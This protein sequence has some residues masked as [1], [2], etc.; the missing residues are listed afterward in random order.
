MKR[1]S[2]KDLAL[3]E[4]KRALLEQL[5]REEGLDSPDEARIPRSENA[6]RARLSFA[7]QRLWFINELEPG[8]PVYTNHFAARLTGT[9]N[10]T[11]L[12]QSVNELVQHHDALRTTF[13]V[14]D[15]RPVQL[16]GPTLSVAMPVV[17]LRSISTAARGPEVRRLAVAEARQPFDL[18]RGPLLR[19][20][21]VRLGSAES[22]L[23]FTVHHIISDGW[24][25][26]VFVTQLGAV[27]EAFCAGKG[28]PLPPL[29]IQYGD[30]AQWQQESLDVI[31]PHLPYWREKLADAQPS[32]D[33]PADHQRPI[34]Q[35]LNGASYHF[36]LPAA[37]N[38]ALKSL[39]RQQSVTLF[40]VL[41]AAFKALLYRYTGQQD[42]SVGSPIAS[43]NRAELKD[44]F[45]C[46]AN[47]LVLRTDVDADLTFQDLLDRVKTTCV[48]AYEHQDMPFEKLVE[49]LQP[50]RDLSRSPL[51]Q[52][53]FVL[54]SFP[55]PNA[56]ADLKLDLIEVDSGTAKFDLT[57]EVLE[58]AE[59]LKATFEY[60]TV[61]FDSET[62]MRMAEHLRILLNGVA[63]DP[64][65][66]VWELPL[67]SEDEKRQLIW[68]FGEDQGEYD[69][70][71]CLHDLFERQARLTP[72]R[73]ALV[74]GDL[75]LSYRELDRRA[76]RLARL[77]T[78]C[79]ARPESLVAVCLPRTAE[80]VTSLLAVLKSGAAYVPLDPAYP[81]ARLELMME[82]SNSLALITD[83]EL[84]GAVPAGRAKVICVEDID[85]ACERLDHSG[86]E[87]GTNADHA[88]RVVSGNLAYLIY[89]SGSTGRPKGVAIEHRSAV[90]MVSWSLG[91][92]TSEELEG[93]LAST[94]ICFDLS[95][96]ELMVP[97]SAGGAVLLVDNAL[98][99]LDEDVRGQVSLINTVP[100]A[101]GEVIRRAA[102]PESV[103]TVNLAGE[104]LSAKL[105][106]EIY[107]GSRAR[108]VVNLY[109]PSEDTTYSTIEEV[110]RGS[111]QVLIGRPISW[112]RAYVADGRGE[113][114]ARGVMGELLI[115]GE[116]LAR[117]YYG[118]AE[119]T[120]ERFIADVAGM[121]AGARVYR[122][123]DVCRVREEKKL[124]YL[125]RGDGQVKVRGYRIELGEVEEALRKV[126]GVKEAA[127]VVEE[128]GGVKRLI[129]Y[130]VMEEEESGGGGRR[131]REEVKEGVPGYMV[132]SQMVEIEAM[133]LTPNRKIDRRAL[134]RIGATPDTRDHVGPRNPMEEIVCEIWAGV[135]GVEKVGVDDNLF[136]IGGH[137]LL[138][139]QIVSRV[140]SLLG[141]EVSLRRLFTA[142]TVAAMAA[143][144]EES[145][146][147]G[148]F[149]SAPPIARADRTR[150]LLLSFAQQRLWLIDRMHP[151]SPVYNIACAVRMLGQLDAAALVK[152]LNEIV[153]RHESLRT[154]FVSIDGEPTQ[155]V[156]DFAGFD[157]E[158]IDLT[159]EGERERERR[160]CELEREEAERGFD[161]ERGSLIRARLLQLGDEEHVLLLTMHHI[162]SDA[163]SI[164][165][166]AR[167]LTQLYEAYREGMP[168]P[169][170][171]LA[172]QYA[173]YAAWQRQWLQ[174]EALDE[175]L[176]YW[177]RQ[178]SGVS[179]LELPTDR[180]RPP[181]ISHRGA[182]ESFSLPA[183]LTQKLNEMSR[184]EGVTLFMSL[185]AGFQLLLARYSGQ[186]DIAVGTSL[187]GRNRVETEALIGF[188]VNTL[189]MRTDLS[190]SPTVKGLL[191]RVRDTALGAYAHQDLPFERL[192]EELQP[193]RNLS[194][195]PLC[196]VMLTFL[197]MP[198]ENLALP[199]LSVVE[200]P[201]RAETAKFD[202]T[203]SFAQQGGEIRGHLQYSTDLFDRARVVRMLTHLHRVFEGMVADADRAVSLIPLLSEEEWR[204]SVVEWNRT[205]AP[206]PSNL[207]VHEKFA[208][209]AKQSPDR[210]AAV[211]E[212]QQISYAEL[213][214]RA[215]QLARHLREVGVG[216]ESRV[217]L[218]IGRGLEMVIG[219]LGVLKAG[220]A[221]VP[222]DPSYPTARLE[223]MLE[224]SSATAVVTLG[225]LV[226]LLPQH[227][228]R[229]VAMDAEWPS[230]SAH[231][232]E[233]L[234]TNVS[235]DNLAYVIYTSG[236]TGKPKGV[237]VRHGAVLNLVEALKASVYANRTPALRVG[238][239]AS[240]CFDASVKQ[241]FQL[242]EGHTLSIVPEAVRFDAGE[243]ASYLA[244][245][246]VD[247]L[248]CTP[249]QLRFLI[250]GLGPTAAPAMMLVGGEAIDESLWGALARSTL[251]DYFN[252]YGP[253]E[254]TVD[255]TA[256]K[257]DQTRV[258]GTIGRPI[259]NAQVYLLDKRMNPV[260]VGV[261]GEMYIAG[262]GLARGYID[263]PD[264]SA[265]RFIPN[266]FAQ[267][268]GARLYRTGDLAQYRASGEIEFLGR[269]DQQV[270][271]R[272]F[273]IELGEIEAILSHHSAI[274]QVV[275][276]VREDIP[277]ERRLAAYL[278]SNERLDAADLQE[279]LRGKL[280]DYMVPTAF[281]Q[282]E[283]I[284][285]TPNGKVDRIALSG[286]EYRPHKQAEEVQGARTATEE[287]I[288]AIWAE[289]LS[290]EQVSIHDNFFDLGGHSLLASRMI[291]RINETFKIELPLRRLFETPTI[292]ALTEA[293]ET[294]MRSDR[295]Q[296]MLPL[297]RFTAGDKLPLS[298]AQQRVWFLDQLEPNTSTYNMPAALRMEGSV[299]IAALEQSIG[300][301]A[302]R[303]EVL[304]ARFDSRQGRPVQMIEPAQPFRIPV[305]DLS[306]LDYQE[307]DAWATRLATQE[308]ARPFDLAR[309]KLLRARLIRLDRQ[310]HLLLINM[311]H[312]VSDGWSVGVFLSE[313]ASLYQS[314]SAGLTS[315][316]DELPIQYS[317]Y[318]RWQKEG[319]Q[320]EL[321]ERQLD[322][323]KQRLA[324]RLPVLDLPTDRPRPTM[325][326][327]CGARHFIVLPHGLTESLKSLGRQE[328]STPYVTLLAAF[329]TLLYRYTSQKDI[330]VGSP[331]AGRGRTEV[332]GLIGFF[333]NTLALRTDLSGD[334]S[335]RDLI[336]TETEIFLEAYAN[337]DVPFEKLVEELQPERS[338]S[339]MPVF[340]VMFVMGEPSRL[341]EMD[342]LKLSQIDVDSGAA[343]F[344]LTVWAKE[345][346][347]GLEMRWEYSA[348]LFD[349]STIG[350]MSHNFQTLLEAIVNDPSQRITLLSLLT[351]EERRELLLGCEKAVGADEGEA[352]LHELFEQ[353]VRRTPDR[354]ALVVG[355]L[356][357]S[358][359]ELDD[360]ASRIARLLRAWGA[361]PESLVGV[362]L[363][364]TAELVIALLG[365]LK[366]GSAYVPLDPTYP[367]AR[368]G[369][370]MEDSNS[371]MLITQRE[372]AELVP[373]GRAKVIC[374]E[375]IEEAVAAVGESRQEARRAIW[376]NL[377]Y[378][379]YTSG[380]TGRP[381][382]VA[383]THRSAV[384]LVRWALG[385]FAEEE[386]AGVLASTSICFD[387]SVF[388]L[389]VPLSAGGAVLLVDNALT[390]LDEDVRGQVSLINTV[391]SAMGEVIRRAAVPESVLT[392][393]LAGEALSAKLVEE[394]YEGSRARRV[395]NLYGP[396]ED[397]TYSTIEEVAR[398]SRQ[399][400][401]GRP[402]SWSRA[403]VADGRGEVAARGVMGELLIGGE[404]LARCYYGR[405]ELTAERFIADVAGM[406]AGARVYRTGDV[407]RVREEKKLEY[408]G[409][410][411]GQVKV[412]GYRI[413]LGEVEEALRKVRGVKEAAVV[414][415]EEGGVKRLIGYV[416]MEEE[417][418]GGGGRRVREEV[419]ERVPG[420][421]VPSQVVEIEAMPLTPNGKIDRKALLRMKVVTEGA[422]QREP[423][424]VIEEML[425]GIWEEVLGVEG[426]RAEEN[427]FEIGGHS[428]L[429][430]Q[431]VSRVRDAFSIDLEMR[432]LFEKSSVAELA[433]VIRE[434]RETAATFKMLPIKAYPR[435]GAMPLSF[436]QEGLW[437]IDQLESGSGFYNLV[438]AFHLKGCLNVDTLEHTIDEISRRH[439]VLRTTFQTV[440]G[441]PV[442]VIHD[443][444]TVRVR[445]INLTG[446]SEHERKTEADALIAS[447][448]I[449]PFDLMRGP[450]AR[451]SLIKLGDEEHLLVMVNHHI[452][453]DAWSLKVY[454]D[455]IQS[456]YEE[457]LKG[458][459]SPLPELPVQYA[460][461]SSWQREWLSEEVLKSRLAYWK[462]A[463]AGVP[464]QINLPTDRPRPPRQTFKGASL[465]LE[466]P[467]DLT[468][469]LTELSNRQDVT[470]YMTLLAA[471]NVLLNY[472]TD[473]EEIIIGSPFGNRD[474][475]EIEGLIGLFVN[476]VVLC[477]DFSGNPSFEELLARTRKTVLGAYT[478]KDLPFAMLVDEFSPQ[479][480]L[481]YNPLSQVRFSLNDIAVPELR[482]STLT[483][484]QLP[485]DSSTTQ[486]DLILRMIKSGRR[487]FG[488]LQYST[489]LYDASTVA[490]MVQQYETVL[491]QI[492]ERPEATLAEIK[493]AL[494]EEELRQRQAE[495]ERAERAS[496]RKFSEMRQ[497]AI[498]RL[499]AEG[500]HT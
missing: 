445:L 497:K 290:V 241:L 325:Q 200:E 158:L 197:D 186:D 468:K 251:T 434:K 266:P 70:E 309:G 408:L 232:D 159:Q 337:Q 89:T 471:F 80:L 272:G 253:T 356:R 227:S 217:G 268:P 338:L 306:G 22:V 300:E 237:M 308:A 223:F 259:A 402:I 396:S 370:M 333:A 7:Q 258:A 199:G 30:Y 104:A 429:A 489:D 275:V 393:N 132:P 305:T 37:L 36:E 81:A 172:A 178:L 355:D 48:D 51:F 179:P 311:H 494:A 66:K 301:V 219:L 314:L 24:S 116:G 248:D 415:E 115:G 330:I 215:N 12:V 98:T 27:Y 90:A 28:S 426:V 319:L 369:L 209:Q 157:V 240:L 136:E 389:M 404:G 99:L 315:P 15:D 94:S 16:I 213:D 239:N 263:R 265:E 341:S 331:F 208:R 394:I 61:L 384:V 430:T 479:R 339:H 114:A 295:G 168:S 56:M 74:V 244:R 499:R 416:V 403:Y 374:V 270:K 138:A 464:I 371:L 126:R 446:A 274:E 435:N 123:G 19:T 122:T 340:Q 368:L 62:I 428:L 127:V 187:A 87:Q 352:C 345:G 188:F 229:C 293:I 433:E 207:C 478:N 25:L 108:R 150:G 482:V 129:G 344:D 23:L 205:E 212:D 220:A 189:V 18:E 381:K 362:C 349:S 401:I 328:R 323:W 467:D 105:V 250:D 204:Q 185:L 193:E 155:R 448:A 151:G 425:T 350:R 181:V 182:S 162:V 246:C 50:E 95:V 234:D 400:L 410:G 460:D 85:Q 421:M 255:A 469:A 224:D 133:P 169:L 366:S 332:E 71:A 269:A 493:A 141:V 477:T 455:E 47:V 35:T 316:L 144:V 376:D 86:F 121:E 439:E 360:R 225:E 190:G 21:L 6:D 196:Q 353:Q 171:E 365:V 431:V 262:E 10:L 424:N 201:R 490:R 202:L 11:A 285:L 139:T 238:V 459:A 286:P 247:V 128:E 49:I 321:L 191:G 465:D 57:L 118:R 419:K 461:Y 359:R 473:Q 438:S 176:Q 131:V 59:G 318:A 135:L 466:L 414:V 282:A 164:G 65:K 386:L 63:S 45:G 444:A 436:A 313:T 364:R 254:V 160:V 470:L 75:R 156:N 336:K 260:P 148:E 484:T 279:Y 113:V 106:E 249:T 218:F 346:E 109:G 432:T 375:E 458:N 298:F 17:D 163:W 78:T 231:S 397:T 392:V 407:C 184:R 153:R 357:L 76:S 154:N 235:A 411:D 329:K 457:F 354:V 447:E 101:M 288:S 4:K 137:S 358:Y 8:N 226:S 222:L 41:L 72:D 177:K 453:G 58:K 34:V 399:V 310:A 348:D 9:I 39:S 110:A 273:R 342:G 102:V 124:E 324:G 88:R 326:S 119:L 475:I 152:G 43:R 117:C 32:L 52:V 264:S 456:I 38:S 291:A 140:R 382:G 2:R 44:L 214:R 203:L 307:R 257:V 299:N 112:S 495:E 418:S 143:E 391:P 192:V 395:V 55:I 134:A 68:G 111:R 406:E 174:A 245:H 487:V 334:P 409:R 54:Q 320:G 449:R 206:Y 361:G 267:R 31:T 230:I 149:Q 84:V 146:H 173:D 292:A 228:Q 486:S 64:R 380:S 440:G 216:P 442:Q 147:V 423:R 13:A 379:I 481:S 92:Y 242:L 476:I 405:A 367:A 491:G 243:M 390:L 335:F 463:L 120:A 297:E 412:R 280:P 462:E 289:A 496:L 327:F 271:V 480:N 183:E 198:W 161:L 166:M 236:S 20:T 60:S 383:I 103:L 287:V 472:Y 322:Y 343:R 69:R 77:L 211:C 107:E 96:F 488:S 294:R 483:I 91:E 492:V 474:H 125:G 283:Q 67:L 351:E 29:P 485:L 420:Y 175:Q 451:F 26:S 427:F 180:P 387:L 261:P 195:P 277:G 42:I 441:H 167:E 377:A 317:D 33:L 422:E 347:Q 385:E 398:G 498:K 450:L 281:V 221:Y 73:I 40:M 363:P 252:V 372:L 210:I 278:V 1:F 79:G 304:R 454:A 142:P 82:D 437:F 256:C 373:A 165:V 500:D 14:V 378:L 312:I 417:E 3:S 452:V 296:P 97:L 302:R 303:H 53:M 5:I 413:E 145:I 130:V 276:D 388:E 443:A 83:R 100:S 194:R 233:A 46:F 170:P 284:P 93:V